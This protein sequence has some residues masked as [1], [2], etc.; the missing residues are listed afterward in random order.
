MYSPSNEER[1]QKAEV[2][3]SVLRQELVAAEV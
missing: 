2:E 1:S 3:I